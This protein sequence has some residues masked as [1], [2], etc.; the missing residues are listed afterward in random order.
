MRGL[1]HCCRNFIIVP[2]ARKFSKL[3][4]NF[5]KLPANF[6]KFR[7]HRDKPTGAILASYRRL[8]PRSYP[9][10]VQGT[11]ATRAHR[12][13]SA[14]LLLERKLAAIEAERDAATANARRVY[15]WRQF[16]GGP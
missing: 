1:V 12:C 3:P 15:I 11:M 5:S 10:K 8:L 7:T 4:A 6:S 14:L 2:R 13:H 9:D 16:P